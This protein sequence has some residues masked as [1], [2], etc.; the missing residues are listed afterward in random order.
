MRREAMVADEVVVDEIVNEVVDEVLNE[1]TPRRAT[2]EGSL[3]GEKNLQTPTI[4]SVNEY[5]ANAFPT[6]D[7]R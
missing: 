7:C 3:P 1:K 2:T 4:V 6:S 5:A